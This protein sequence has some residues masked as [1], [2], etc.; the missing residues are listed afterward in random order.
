[1]VNGRSDGSKKSRMDSVLSF[2]AQGKITMTSRPNQQCCMDYT[3]NHSK[4]R[5]NR[6]LLNLKV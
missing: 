4:G 5:R 2:V 1:M 6:G 3:V